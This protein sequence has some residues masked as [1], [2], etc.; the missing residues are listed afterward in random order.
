MRFVGFIGIFAGLLLGQQEPEARIRTEV[1]QVLV[2]VVVTDAKGHHATGL[3][4]EDFT[5]LED[6]V[7]QEV[8]SFSIE[9]EAGAGGVVRAAGGASGSAVGGGSTAQ[10]RTYVICFDTLH[11]S[12]ANFG[13]VRQ[14]MEKLFQKDNGTGAQ[15]VMVSLGRQLRVVQTATSDQKLLQARLHDKG[16]LDVLRGVDAEAMAVEVNATK[17]RLEQYC[18]RCPCG[19]TARGA[20]CYPERQELRQQLT[21]QASRTS[22]LG[23][24]FLEGLKGLLNELGNVA[25][26]RTLVLISDGFSLT[27]GAEFFA[28]ASA[29]LPNYA[30]FAFS[31]ENLNPQMEEALA[32]ATKR[33]IR[34]YG[35][36]SRGLGSPSFAAGGLSD[37]GSSGMSQNGARNRGG[38]MMTEMDRKQNSLAFLN[39]AGMAQLASATGGIYLHDSNDLL[40]ELQQVLADGREFYLLSYISS[41]TAE[42]GKYRKIGV[43][44]RDPKLTVRA[45]EGYWAEVSR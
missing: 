23:V 38:S 10:A 21:M 13:H 35:V 43:A 24:G 6:G 25:G 22:M 14:A 17:T 29:F 16:F 11:S 5:V 26:G 39:G 31:T 44:V 42:D 34:V 9:A 7:R 18:K 37:A 19:A 2:P 28:V 1:R 32:I 40:G 36:D 8:R 27:P 12:F 3:K 33:D 4:A 41:N 30:E 15:Y 45:K 20:A